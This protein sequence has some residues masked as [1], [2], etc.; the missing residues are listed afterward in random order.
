M[1]AN[2][3]TI[4]DTAIGRC[5]IAW[6]E[7]GVVELQLPEADDAKT[8][9]R[10]L[11]HRP[12]LIEAAPPSEVQQAIEAIQALLRGEKI[13]LSSVPVDL[14]SADEFNRRVYEIART[15]PAGETMTYGEIATRLG[16]LQL[17]R[18]VGQAL[19]QNP[20]AIIV[21]C[22]R[23][24][25]ADRKPG[26]FSAGGGVHTKLKILSIERAHIGGTR[27]LFDLV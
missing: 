20:V 11:R 13:D 25:G 9:A 2:G 12:E 26:G 1:T 27:D 16:D 7:R 15:I 17:S 23:V 21:P 10:M 22:H 6:S 5:G 4:F 14:D 19:G 18:A 8:V 24:L 3:Y